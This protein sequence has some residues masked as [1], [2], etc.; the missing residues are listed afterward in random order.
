MQEGSRDRTVIGQSLSFHV[1]QPRVDEPVYG[2]HDALGRSAA[3][4][5]ACCRA[6]SDMRDGSRPPNGRN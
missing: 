6:G 1:S 3:R 5:N 4:D 2:N